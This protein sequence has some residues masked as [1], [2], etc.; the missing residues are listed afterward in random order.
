[1][2]RFLPWIIFAV[3]AASIAG[4]WLPQKAAK[5]GFRFWQVWRDPR[6]RGR[7]GQTVGHCCA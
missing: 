7:S 2:K 4:N 1:M 5:E 6:A 3:A